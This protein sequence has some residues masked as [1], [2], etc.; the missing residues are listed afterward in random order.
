[1][2]LT[3]AQ[4]SPKLQIRRPPAVKVCNYVREDAV[5]VEQENSCSANLPQISKDHNEKPVCFYKQFLV[6]IRVKG[7]TSFLSLMN[8]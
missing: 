4:N 1:M 8:D 2:P 6:D 3:K 5:V 7:V